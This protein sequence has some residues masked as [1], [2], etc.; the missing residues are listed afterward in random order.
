MDHLIL[1]K[2]NSSTLNTTYKFTNDILITLNNERKCGGIFFYREK[3]FNY[4]DHNI[5]LTKIKYCGIN[6]VMYA[7]IESYLGNRYQRMTN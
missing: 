5:L 4:V 2:K 7:L 1:N 6:G 3:A